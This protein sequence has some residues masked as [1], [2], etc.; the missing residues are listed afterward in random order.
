M[1][2]TFGSSGILEMFLALLIA[3]GVILLIREVVM[4]YWKINRI[5]ENQ[6]EEIRLLR[7][8]VE[9]ISAREN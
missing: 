4:W 7:K 9:K 1:M 3:I 5:V 2:G 8:L 6:E